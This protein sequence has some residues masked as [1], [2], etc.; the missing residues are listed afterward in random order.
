VNP[1]VTFTDSGRKWRCNICSM[2]NDGNLSKISFSINHLI[3]DA[4]TSILSG[5]YL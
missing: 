1:F 4:R 3:D 5:I 2:L